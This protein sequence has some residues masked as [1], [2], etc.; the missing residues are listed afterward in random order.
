MNIRSVYHSCSNQPNSKVS[1][2][3]IHR[4]CKSSVVP[5]ADLVVSCFIFLVD[6]MSAADSSCHALH[7]NPDDIVVRTRSVW[8]RCDI[9]RQEQA[10]YYTALFF[11]NPASSEEEQGVSQEGVEARRG[12]GWLFGFKGNHN[13]F[14]QKAHSLEYSVT[15]SLVPSS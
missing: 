5:V 14:N 12:P 10:T 7:N 8:W 6:N 2:S 1:I 9:W 15:E 13:V 11:P 4:K 3:V